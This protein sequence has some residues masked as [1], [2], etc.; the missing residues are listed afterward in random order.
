MTRAQD[1]EAETK[2]RGEELK[3]L[4][5]AKRII[6]EAT[7]GASS[8]LQVDRSHMSSSEELANFEAVRVVRDLARKQ[9]SQVLAQ[10]ASRMAAAMREG[11]GDPFSKVKGLLVD[12]IAKLELEA[13]E[14]ATKKAYCDKELKETNAK[15]VEKST[16]IEVL[17][18]RIDQTSAKSSKL[19]AEVATLQNQLAKLAKSQ[20]EMNKMRLDEHDAYDSAKAEQEKGLEGVKMAMQVLK[21]YY[22][23]DAVHGAA[24]GAAGGIVSLLETVESDMTQS[25]AELVTQEETAVAEYERISKNNE[26]EKASTDQDIAY[27]AK[28]AKQLDKSTSE[29]LADR[30]NVQAELDAVLEY[31]GKIE[32]QCI[33]KP[34]R[35]AERVRRREAEI[36]GLKD[37]LNILESETALLQRLGLHQRLRGVHRRSV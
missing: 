37:A 36:A 34:E 7:G 15:K 12:M 35:Y 20:G 14:D 29:N 25:L 2:S 33:A 3:A 22:S 21:E 9:H 8:F 1:F 5:E 19:K 6:K 24:V 30:S 10:L 27:K 16:E 23:S 4:A 13:G 31:L 32:E 17:S 11:S 18:T 28:E 26:I